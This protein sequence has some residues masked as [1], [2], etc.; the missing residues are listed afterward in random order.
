MGL[1]ILPDYFDSAVQFMDLRHRSEAATIKVLF[2]TQ[3]LSLDEF[4]PASPAIPYIQNNSFD[5][6][7]PTIFIS[8]ALRSPTISS[9]NHISCRG[10]DDG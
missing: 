6:V 5:W 7:C 4:L 3:G 2:R 8:S 9:R 10:R 1:A